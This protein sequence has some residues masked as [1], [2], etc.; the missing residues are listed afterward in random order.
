MKSNLNLN[1]YEVLQ[2]APTAEAEVIQAVYRRLARKYHPDANGDLASTEKMKVL[3][4]AYTVLSDPARRKKYDQT[5]RR[6]APPPAAKKTKAEKVLLY[7]SKLCGD[8]ERWLEVSDD[9]CE[10]DAHDG[11]FHLVVTRPGW[12]SERL[13]PVKVT[14]FELRLKAQFPGSNGRGAECGILFRKNSA[15]FYK[16][17]MRRDGYFGFGVRAKDQWLRLIDHQ[18][19]EL[20]DDDVNTLMVKA[21][22]RKLKLGVNGELLA[23]LQDDRFVEGQIGFYVATGDDE[24][25][26][27]ARFRDL[28]VYAL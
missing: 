8:R 14:N 7:Q 20:F 4:E 19:S 12:V 9:H 17:A 11:F 13:A 6:P 5:L 16:F 24:T 3:N 1:Y 18:H 26:A 23:S 15:G 10:T 25:F 2:V 27:Q 21:V 22:G 28:S